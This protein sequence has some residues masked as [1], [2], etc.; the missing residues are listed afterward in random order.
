M[1]EQL[2]LTDPAGSV[3]PPK[4]RIKPL[5]SSGTKKEPTSIVRSALLRLSSKD[6][7]QFDPLRAFSAAAFS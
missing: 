5:S 6:S 3:H 4:A 1:I 7:V 2:E